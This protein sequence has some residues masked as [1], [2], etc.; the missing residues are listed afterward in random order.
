LYGRRKTVAEKTETR[1]CSATCKNGR[2]CRNQALPGLEVCGLHQAQGPAEPPLPE[3]TVVEWAGAYE[4]VRPGDLVFCR[5]RGCCR[6][7]RTGHAGPLVVCDDEGSLWEVDVGPRGPTTQYVL[8]QRV[9]LRPPPGEDDEGDEEEGDEPPPVVRRPDARLV[10]FRHR[11][12]ELVRDLARDVLAAAGRGNAAQVAK[13]INSRWL[14]KGGGKHSEM[15]AAGFRA[16]AEWLVKM[17]KW[18]QIGRMPEW[19]RE[20]VGE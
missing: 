5:G 16:K 17:R 20:A 11:V 1:S 3:G 18:V 9:E 7:V 19:L 4:D 13:A 12:N 8:Y 15:D 14:Y 2:R 6:V 10:V